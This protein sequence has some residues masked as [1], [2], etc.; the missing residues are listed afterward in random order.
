MESH[1]KVL[2]IIFIA[3]AAFQVVVLSLLSV[4]LSTI[5]SYAISQTNPEDTRI[6]EIVLE[7]MRY[8]PFI[9]IIFFSLPTLI[10]GIGLV[11]KQKW[12]LILALII[13]CLKLFSFPIGTAIGVYAIWVYSEDNRLSKVS[14]NP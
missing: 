14:P 10:A 1:K 8:L 13:G 11:K 6:L 4:F 7:F 9:V 12:A 2:G 3:S 5:F